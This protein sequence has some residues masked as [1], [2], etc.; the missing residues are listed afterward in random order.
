MRNSNEL[1]KRGIIAVYKMML[2][3]NIIKQNGP[4]YHRM[5]QLERQ[6]IKETRWLSGRSKDDD[7]VSFSWLQEKDLN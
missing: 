1:K 3:K 5:R 7:S 6:Y 4:A 2:K